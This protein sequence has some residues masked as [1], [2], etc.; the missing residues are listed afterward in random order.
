MPIRLADSV[1]LKNIAAQ[2][3]IIVYALC[4]VKLTSTCDENN[5]CYFVDSVYTMRRHEAN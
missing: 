5:P 1:R 3:I 2:V 4:T